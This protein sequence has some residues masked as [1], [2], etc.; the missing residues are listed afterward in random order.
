[1]ATCGNEGVAGLLDAES[2]FRRIRGHRQMKD[3]IE[4]LQRD[5]EPGSL[6]SQRKEN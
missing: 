3:L 1:M 2:R 6:V 5:V 4:S